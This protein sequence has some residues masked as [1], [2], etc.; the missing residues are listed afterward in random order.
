MVDKL[1]SFGAVVMQNVLEHTEDPIELLQAAYNLL[2]PGGVLLA[3]VP[4]D[5]S[6]LQRVVKSTHGAYWHVPD[7]VHYFTPDSLT[8]LFVW[9]GFDIQDM[10]GTFPMELFLVSGL[11][12]VRDKT[13]G[14]DA[15][16]CR[17]DIEAQYDDRLNNLYRELIKLGIGR[18]IVLI[19]Q[20]P[21][22]KKADADE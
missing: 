14:K 7:H 9:V 10:I 5:K 15:H 4:N 11:D 3:V 19:A 6:P 13:L 16:R 21:E 18:E 1:P 17:A 20:K 8:R 12:Y 2:I 22:E